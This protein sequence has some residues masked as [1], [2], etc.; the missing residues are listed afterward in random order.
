MTTQHG[1]DD[2]EFTDEDAGCGELTPRP[3]GMN[4]TTCRASQN[5]YALLTSRLGLASAP[6]EELGG[7]AASPGRGPGALVWIGLAF[8]RRRR[9]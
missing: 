5:S 8:L 2:R 7:C 6:A 3:C 9:R 4:G 1:L